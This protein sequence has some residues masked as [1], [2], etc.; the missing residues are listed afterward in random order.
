MQLDKQRKGNDSS[1][2]LKK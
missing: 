1:R 2:Y